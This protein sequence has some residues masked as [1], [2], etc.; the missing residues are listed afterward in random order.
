MNAQL[1]DVRRKNRAA[2]GLAG[3]GC[4]P[5]VP[6]MGCCDS[7]ERGGTCSGKA[8]PGPAPAALGAY[9]G[10]HAW[11]RA[12]PGMGFSLPSTI[13]PVTVEL[14]F[15]NVQYTYD[16]SQPSAPSGEGGIVGTWLMQHIVRPKVT[17][18]G[19]TIDTG[20]GY[21]DYSGLANMI[22][23]GLVVLGIIGGVY[24]GYRTFFGGR[25]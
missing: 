16:A 23:D 1:E 13:P 24:A 21:A 9:T 20:Q 19:V 18:L 7:C 10:Q 14:S 5:S 3:V 15:P 2:M 12:I 8:L 25:P 6:G 22:M 17:T 11:A 4:G